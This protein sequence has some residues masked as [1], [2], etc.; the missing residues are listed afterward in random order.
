MKK[1][2]L[3]FAVIL[4][5]AGLA[6]KVSAQVVPVLNN[7]GGEIIS[8]I[9]LE[10][11]NPLEFGRVAALAAGGNVIITAAADPNPIVSGSGVSLVAGG[12]TRSAASYTVGG[13][14]YSYAINFVDPIITLTGSVSGTMTI[15]ELK[16]SSLN[17]G[18]T[19][20]IGLISGGSDTFWVGGKLVIGSSQPAGLYTGTFS[21]SVNYN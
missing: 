16:S 5:M 7:A 21:V 3:I 9:T 1:L 18:I 12:A 2:L 14:N 4:M 20:G 13:A 19:S 10:V 11:V 17:G 6:D 15:I 8:P